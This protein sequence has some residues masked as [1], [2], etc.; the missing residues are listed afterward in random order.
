[1]T[2]RVL[3]T[4]VAAALLAACGKYAPPLRAGEASAAS[5][6]GATAGHPADCEDPEHDHDAS[7]ETP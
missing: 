4:L 2:R 6:G 1:M 5:A 7:R 3:A